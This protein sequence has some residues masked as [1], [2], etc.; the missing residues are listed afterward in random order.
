MGNF[1]SISTVMRC[2]LKKGVS[3][4]EQIP[5][6][7]IIKAVLQFLGKISWPIIIGG[8]IYYFKDSIK[9]LLKDSDRIKFTKDG[10]EFQKQVDEIKQQYESLSYSKDQVE[11]LIQT[12]LKNKN[13]QINKATSSSAIPASLEELSQK[14]L[15]CKITN[16]RERIKY[17]DDVT[18]EM[19]NIVTLENVNR[20]LLAESGNQALILAYATSVSINPRDEDVDLLLKNARN[21][22]KPHAKYRITLT[23]TELLRRRYIRSE[24]F[25]QLEEL[26]S[27][28]ESDP[29]KKPDEPLK[30]SIGT[31]RRFMKTES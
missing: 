17:L 26:L 21:V 8:L 29:K 6:V 11:S 19:G 10:I 31:I 7:E 13:I 20:K 28:Y 27:I 18:K 14:Y 2:L 3:M 15:N 4:A 23:L 24:N 16:R 30:R 5:Y 12:I 22:R 25:D 1:S 9:K